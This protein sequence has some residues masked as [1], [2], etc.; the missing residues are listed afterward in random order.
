MSSQWVDGNGNKWRF[1]TVTKRW[2]TLVN[3]VWTVRPLPSGGLSRSDVTTSPGVV[4]VETMGPQGP[5]GE[6]G[7]PGEAA[8][9]EVIPTEVQNGIED[10]FPLQYHADLSK[11]F[12]VFRNGLMES[13]NSSYV[14]TSTHVTFS[15]PPLESDFV[16]L[17]YYKIS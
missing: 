7:P 14:P 9:Q 15:S 1:S 16:T 3:G 17:V 11:S 12:Q 13:R 10:T 2:Q 8:I 4:V 6:P 5:P